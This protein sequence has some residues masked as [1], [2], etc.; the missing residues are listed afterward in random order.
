MLNWGVSA[1]K[2]GAKVPERVNKDF[3]AWLASTDCAPRCGAPFSASRL[4]AR[5]V[6]PILH[7][8]VEFPS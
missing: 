7:K 6:R 5:R 3:E 8:H 1:E 2:I 4:R